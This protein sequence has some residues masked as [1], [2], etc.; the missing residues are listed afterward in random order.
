MVGLTWS[1]G[2]RI[3]ACS[4]TRGPVRTSATA[5][6]HLPLVEVLLELT[7][8]GV[9]RQTILLAGTQAPSPVEEGLVVTDQILFEDCDVT[10]GGLQVEVAQQ[11]GADVDWQAVVDQVGGKRCAGNHVA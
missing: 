5:E 10:A 8:F 11:S 7:P 6:L 2:Q 1:I 3:H 9:G 4:C